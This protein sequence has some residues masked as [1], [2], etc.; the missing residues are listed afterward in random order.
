[1]FV[2][3]RKIFFFFLQIYIYFFVKGNRWLSLFPGACYPYY[4][5]EVIRNDWTSVKIGLQTR[6][7]MIQS[8]EQFVI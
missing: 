1:M 8:E 2:T 5:D 4:L 3:I 7:L 6:H